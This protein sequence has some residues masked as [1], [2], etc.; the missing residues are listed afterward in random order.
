MTR[1]TTQPAETLFDSLIVG[2]GPAGLTAALYL[3]RY[4]R[5]VVVLHDGTARALRIP[6]THNA[7]GFPDG[8]AGTELI[9]RMM[10]HASNYGASFAEAKIVSAARGDGIFELT[11]DDGRLWRGRSL[12][13][14]TGILLNQ[15]PLDEAEHQ[16]AVEA[17]ALRYCPIC[18]GYEHI[19]H[20]IAVIGTDTQGTKEALFLRQF[21]SRLTL[22]PKNVVELSG[23]ER[24]ALDRA[25]VAVIDTPVDHY[26][27]IEGAMR[28]TF[29]S[30]AQRSFDVVYP[31]LGCRPRTELAVALGITTDDDGCLDPHTPFE[32]QIPGFYSAGDIVEGLD[33]IAVAVS[34]GA[35][36]ATK[37]HNWLREED[38]EALAE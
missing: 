26:A 37:A 11:A 27:L 34:H 23:M 9:D 32:T 16:A 8:I 33:Q 1:E 36:A 6:R 12:I 3:G 7:P 29:A 4:R 13:L 35:I 24:D 21:S 30:G 22:V 17:G 28:L 20:D 18:D 19:D 31:A 25:G 5:R 38:S 15:L 2:A 14:A 10:R